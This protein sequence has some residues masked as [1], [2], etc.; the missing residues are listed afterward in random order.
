MTSIAR[1]T[2]KSLQWDE[3]RIGDEKDSPKFTRA[4]CR[5]KYSGDI[6][7]ESS[8]EY[9]MCYLEDGTAIFTGME[10]IIG[11]LAG[12]SGSFVLRHEGF[13]ADGV[14][15]MRLSIVDGSGTGELAGVAGTS[16]FESPHAEEYPITLE[17]TLSPE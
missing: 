11:R 15:K 12:R 4:S 16:E 2:F 8:L 5:Q 7:G 3:T 1:A 9:L 6:E 10:R 13:F 14:A 17:Y